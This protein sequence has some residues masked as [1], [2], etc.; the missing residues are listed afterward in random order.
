[1]SASRPEPAGN[2]RGPLTGQRGLEDW[3]PAEL[4]ALAP[5]IAV[6]GDVMLDGWW[7]GT[8]DRLCREGPAPVVDIR[9]RSF[10]PGGRTSGWWRC[11]APSCRG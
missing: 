2:R 9:T 7:T 11:A 1:M 4:A 8:I 6:V 5:S 10:A 3:L